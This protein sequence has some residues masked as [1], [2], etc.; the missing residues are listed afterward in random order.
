MHTFNA[1]QQ[2]RRDHPALEI[3]EKIKPIPVYF[4]KQVH[5][6]AQR[7]H[8]IYI[9]RQYPSLHSLFSH[10]PLLFYAANIII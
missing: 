2:P 1:I 5:L 10:I 8:L 3:V 4:S 6:L 9:G 7:S